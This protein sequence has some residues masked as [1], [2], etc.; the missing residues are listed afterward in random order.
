MSTAWALIVSLF[1]LAANG[2]FV[3]AEFALV[4][5]KRHRLAEL[6]ADGSLSARLAVRGSRHLT[7][8]LAGAQLGITLCTLGL[9]ALAK[10]A[11]AHLLDPLLAATGLPGGVSYVIAFLLSIAIVVFLHM[12]IGEMAPKSWAIS[13]PEK[14]ALALS[15]PFEGYIWLTKPLLLLLNGAAN[16]TLRMAKVTPKNEIDDSHKPE[17]LAVLLRQSR[18]DGLLHEQQHRIL[19]GVLKLRATTVGELMRPREELVTV[20]PEADNDEVE[21]VSLASGRSRLVAVDGDRPLGIVH[22]RDALKQP[23][24]GA[25]DLLSEPLTLPEDTPISRAVATMRAERAQ[26]AL[27]TG[28]DGA[29]RG[30]VAL[31]DLLEQVLG[32]FDDETDAM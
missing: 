19:S 21:R 29:L 28:T 16:L 5:V 11:I 30:L 22:I 3:A 24:A 10:P 13:H 27:V 15:V 9:G 2:F 23:T 6:A 1:L 8:T 32:D 17:D 31:E 26:V 4:S 7:V 14:S 20:G 18:E 12:V 25:A